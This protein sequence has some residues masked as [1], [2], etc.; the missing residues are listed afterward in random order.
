MA[1]ASASVALEVRRVLP[2]TP[3]AVFAAWTQAEALG[4][5]FAPTDDMTTV[6][7]HLDARAGGSYRIEMRS[8][9]GT[10]YVVRGTYTEF[11][12]PH[13][14]AFTWA[15]EGQDAEES[16]VELQLRSAGA[17]C[18]LVLRHSRFAAEASR[19]GHLQGWEGSLGRLFAV[20]TTN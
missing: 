6:V 13:R 16:L 1:N 11:D 12:A 7:H 15:W 17:G 9:D 5:W 2:V 20:L 14:L 3:E 19:D 18:E 4:A 10:R 8:V